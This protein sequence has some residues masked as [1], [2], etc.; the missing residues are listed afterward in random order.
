MVAATM[1]VKAAVFNYQRVGL[2][3]CRLV[4][5][6]MRRQAA[7]DSHKQGRYESQDDRSVTVS[8]SRKMDGKQIVRGIAK[9]ATPILGLVR[10]TRF[11]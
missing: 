7:V 8:V 11:L 4:L 10:N 2:F 6:V 1:A 5:R 3:L 9:L